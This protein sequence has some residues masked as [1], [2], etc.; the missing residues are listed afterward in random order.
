MSL[1]KNNDSNS[2]SKK[3]LL[4][5]SCK[6]YLYVPP[7]TLFGM[8]RI[9][10]LSKA[11][12]ILFFEKIFSQLELC[13]ATISEAYNKEVIRQRNGNKVSSNCFKYQK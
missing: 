3:H 12:S 8:I 9:T 2:L 13:D 5:F 7:S 1:Q 11:L 6:L 10:E 4:I